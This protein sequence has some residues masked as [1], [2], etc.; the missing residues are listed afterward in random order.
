MVFGDFDFFPSSYHPL[1]LSNS[2]PKI[3]KKHQ[4]QKKRRNFCRFL[5][6]STLFI[7]FLDLKLFSRK[8]PTISDP[9]KKIQLDRPRI[10]A[11]SCPK[12]WEN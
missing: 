2:P 3:N 5:N 11:L 8:L 12:K 10:F 1:T 6:L 4:K 7:N 9:P